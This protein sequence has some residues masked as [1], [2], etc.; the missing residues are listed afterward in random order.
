[1]NKTFAILLLALECCS[2]VS[3][4]QK[5]EP[6]IVAIDGIT[7]PYDIESVA[8]IRAESIGESHYAE[9]FRITDK[10]RIGVIRNRLQLLVPSFSKENCLDSRIVC[11]MRG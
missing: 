2:S 8:P 11:L 4:Q 5:E 9:F 6:E 1:M 3:P 10:E 7:I